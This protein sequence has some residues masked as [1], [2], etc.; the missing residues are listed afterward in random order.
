[1][2][3][4][5]TSCDDYIVFFIDCGGSRHV[6]LRLGDFDWVE[7]QLERPVV[8]KVFRFTLCPV[9]ELVVFG[10]GEGGARRASTGNEAHSS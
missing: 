3:T 5:C 4:R 9:V 8:K 10:G 6:T 1:M 7:E 2:G